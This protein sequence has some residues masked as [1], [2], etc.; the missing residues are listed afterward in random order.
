[1]SDNVLWKLLDKKEQAI[2]ESC[3]EHTASALVRH[4]NAENGWAESSLWYTLRK[5][6][7]KGVITW[8]NGL[9]KIRS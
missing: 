8:G 3:G 1:M 7:N 4:L 2:L 9:V 6:K 5:L